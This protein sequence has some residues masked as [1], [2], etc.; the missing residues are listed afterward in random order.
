MSLLTAK[1]F[2][3][4]PAVF[5]FGMHGGRNYPFIKGKC[6]LGIALEDGMGDKAYLDILWQNLNHIHLTVKSEFIFYLSGVDV[7]STNKFD[8]LKLTTDGLAK[9]F[10][11]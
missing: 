1:I 5:T 11:I 6:N 10:V 4:D 2:E 3:T 7:V 8:R 9:K